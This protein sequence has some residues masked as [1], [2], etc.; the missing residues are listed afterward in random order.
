MNFKLCWISF[1]INF[2][3][4][5][6]NVFCLHQ[7]HITKLTNLAI[8]FSSFTLVIDSHRFKFDTYDG[9]FAILFL[10]TDMYYNLVY[11]SCVGNF[12]TILNFMLKF[13]LLHPPWSGNTCS[14]THY[15]YHQDSRNT[16]ARLPLVTFIFINW[17]LYFQIFNSDLFFSLLITI[18]LGI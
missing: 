5:L 16:V 2:V 15:L 9:Q 1:L 8:H 4:F 13:L 18:Y 11:Y 17:Q 7:L 6:F 14:C 10:R 12:V 3:K